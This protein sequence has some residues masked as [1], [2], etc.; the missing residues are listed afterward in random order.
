[1]LNR[2]LVIGRRWNV[3]WHNMSLPIYLPGHVAQIAKRRGILWRL[4]AV[5]YFVIAKNKFPWHCLPDVVIARRG[6]DNYLVMIA[7]EQNVSV[8]DISNNLVAVHQTDTQAK[9]RDRHHIASE[10]NMRLLGTFTSTRGRLTSSQYLTKSV[11]DTIRNTT[12]IVIVRRQMTELKQRR[13]K[14]TERTERRQ[15]SELK[16]K[17][18][19]Y[20]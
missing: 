15:R 5:D 10:Y 13:Q 19:R 9:A 6:Y 1:M 7:V 18:I 12:S 2:T 20:C 3:Y 17:L 11:R 4:D 8:V 16:E 14:T